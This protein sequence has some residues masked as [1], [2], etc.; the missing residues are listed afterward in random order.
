MTNPNK[1]KED[2]IL[3]INNKKDDEIKYIKYETEN[4]D[5]EDVLKSRKIDNDYYKK[6]YKRLNQKNG[7]IIVPESIKGSASKEDVV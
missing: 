6:K 7:F 5:Q 1:E 3:L 4:H 2:P